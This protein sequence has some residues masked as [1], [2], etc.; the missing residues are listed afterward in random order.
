[1]GGDFNLDDDLDEGGEFSDFEPSPEEIAEFKRALQEVNMGFT[2]EM[3][4]DEDG[5]ATGNLKC[6]QCGRVGHLTEHPF[7]HKFACPMRDSVKD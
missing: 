6:N 2:Y 4:K 3:L 5:F 7:P 1:M